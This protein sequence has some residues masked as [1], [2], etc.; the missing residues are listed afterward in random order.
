MPRSLPNVWGELEKERASRAEAKAKFETEAWKT[1][2]EERRLRKENS[3]SKKATFKVAL[4]DEKDL[5]AA[6]E[7]RI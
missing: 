1:L 7:T 5:R 2:E 3:L 4:K 6:A